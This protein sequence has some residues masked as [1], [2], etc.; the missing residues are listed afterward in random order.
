MRSAVSSAFLMK[1]FDSGPTLRVPRVCGLRS[2]QEERPQ[3]A[4]HPAER[5]VLL[6]A[7]AFRRQLF[8]DVD[9]RLQLGVDLAAVADRRR[10]ECV[11]RVVDRV[12]VVEHRFLHGGSDSLLP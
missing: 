5:S 10:I 6:K 1:T 2:D 4:G 11:E 9:G 8:A 12:V 3:V 7:K